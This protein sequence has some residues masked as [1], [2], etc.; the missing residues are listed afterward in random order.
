MGVFSIYLE[1]IVSTGEPGLLYGKRPTNTGPPPDFDGF[2]LTARS[3]A[4]ISESFPF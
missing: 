4:R 3:I 1:P 2:T